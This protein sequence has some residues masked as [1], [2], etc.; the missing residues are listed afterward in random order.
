MKKSK[1]KK[2]KK[3]GFIRDGS[4][5]HFRGLKKTNKKGGFIRDGSIQ[6]FRGLRKSNKKGGFIRDGSIQHFRRLGEKNGGFIRDGS[7]Q[8]FRGLRK[9]NKKGGFIR[10]GSIQHFRRLGEKKGGFIRDGSIQHFRELRKSNKKGGFIR[11]GSIQYFRGLNKNNKK[12]KYKKSKKRGGKRRINKYGGSNNEDAIVRQ[13]ANVDGTGAIDG[14]AVRQQAT[15]YRAAAVDG[16]AIDGQPANVDRAAAIDGQS[17]TVDRTTAIDGQ[18]ATVDR[19]A[20][21]DGQSVTVDRTTAIDGQSATVDRTTAIDG[22]SATVDRTTAI[23]GQ[24]VTV[25][26]TAAID[27]Q[28]ATV[29]RT[30]AI[31]GQSVTVDR[32]A[33]IDGAADRQTATVDGTTIDGQPATVD[34]TAAIDGQ[35]ANV[36]RTTAIYGATAVRRPTAVVGQSATV[37]TNPMTPSEPQQPIT[38]PIPNSIALARKEINNTELNLIRQLDQLRPPLP[39]KSNVLKQQEQKIQDDLATLRTELKKAEQLDSQSKK[40]A[41]KATHDT[42]K[43]LL[44]GIYKKINE[45]KTN[46]INDKSITSADWNNL[47]PPAHLGLN[48]SSESNSTPSIRDLKQGNATPDMTPIIPPSNLPEGHKIPD[49]SDFILDTDHLKSDIYHLNKEDNRFKDFSIIKKM[50]DTTLNTESKDVVIANQ[51]SAALLD[52]YN[53]TAGSLPIDIMTCGPDNTS[54]SNID[55]FQNKYPIF[56]YSKFKTKYNIEDNELKHAHLMTKTIISNY[57][58]HPE[59]NKNPKIN[60]LYKLIF[61]T[62]YESG[63]SPKT[64]G[65]GKWDSRTYNTHIDF[66]QPES[67]K[68]IKSWPAYCSKIERDN[69]CTNITNKEINN[70]LLVTNPI[71]IKANNSMSEYLEE[72]TSFASPSTNRKTYKCNKLHSNWRNSVG[73]K[74]INLSRHVATNT[75]DLPSFEYNIPEGSPD[76]KEQKID[77]KQ[78]YQ[79]KNHINFKYYIE[80]SNNGLHINYAFIVPIN[81]YINYWWLAE[82]GLT[83]D[84]EE[85]LKKAHDSVGVF[86]SSNDPSLIIEKWTKSEGD[87]P[88]K[89]IDSSKWDLVK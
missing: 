66:I 1:N 37:G 85:D 12:R 31:D 52:E 87:T 7:I 60:N 89:N 30:T 38:E 41:S 14:A 76:F 56:D 54:L 74:T 2:S 3:G 27:G 13:P 53:C 33:A 75:S 15:V 45:M 40:G 16:T 5:Q 44:V 43:K 68:N 49:I 64:Y 20:A 9:S 83:I 6:H 29:D 58:I 17:A 28:S 59:A 32:T 72:E 24:S 21:I 78:Q 77:V 82:S 69:V 23:D 70:G 62:S 50:V 26:R 81:Y 48:S 65:T 67:K 71:F 11:D 18:S 84:N 22:Q 19:A 73:A 57:F 4:I 42:L 10:D 8:H 25:D 79:T 86:T 88:T 80:K 61:F 36:D 39:E 35:S 46:Y 55:G 63:D 47:R 34:R 51:N